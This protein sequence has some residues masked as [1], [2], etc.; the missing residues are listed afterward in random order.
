MAY[1]TFLILYFSGGNINR[2]IAIISLSSREIARL[3]YV[4][5]RFV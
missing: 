3:T 2:E 5:K 1:A 4:N